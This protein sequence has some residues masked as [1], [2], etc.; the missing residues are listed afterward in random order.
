L[1]AL[2]R[3]IDDIAFEPPNAK[4][5]TY[6]MNRDVT[7]IS[8]EVKFNDSRIRSCSLRARKIG[9]FGTLD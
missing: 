6:C 5:V 3:S 9:I 4:K 8:T 2:E 1:Y 7:V